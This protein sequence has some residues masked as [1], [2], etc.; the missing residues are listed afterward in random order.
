MT[1]YFTIYLL[2]LL[3]ILL[4]SSETHLNKFELYLFFTEFIFSYHVN[5]TKKPEVYENQFY[6]HCRKGKCDQSF[7][8]GIIQ[9]GCANVAIATLKIDS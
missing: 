4:S 9:T 6:S 3:Y 5:G 1:H 2:L 8:A 7:V